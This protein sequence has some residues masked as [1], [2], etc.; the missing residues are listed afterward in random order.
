MVTGTV[1][2]FTRD[3]AT[4]AIEGAAARH[5]ARCRR[6]PSASWWGESPGA[7]KLTKATELGVPIVAGERF[8]RLLETGEV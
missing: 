6:G 2:G 4:A 7:S 5:P 8:A 1:Q 3:E